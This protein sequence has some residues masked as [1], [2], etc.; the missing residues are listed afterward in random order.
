MYS[1]VTEHHIIA[2]ILLLT[3]GGV[4]AVAATPG[5]RAQSRTHT[6]HTTRHFGVC[7]VRCGFL[8][9]TQDLTAAICYVT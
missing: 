2:H 9:D 4:G 5:T 1:T 7:A 8:A 6:A 3:R